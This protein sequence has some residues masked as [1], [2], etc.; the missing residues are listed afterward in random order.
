VDTVARIAKELQVLR[1]V[2]RIFITQSRDH[3]AGAQNQLAFQGRAHEP[4]NKK[5]FGIDGIPSD[6]SIREI[7]D[8]IDIEHLNEA[9]ANTFHELQSG[10][11]LRQFVFR[12]DHY[13]LAID[14][15]GYCCLTSIAQSPWS[16]KL[17]RAI[18]SL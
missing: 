1:F 2:S 8:G 5:P 15:A 17:A 6:T 9:F 4:A 18:L 10:S 3:D 12:N 13:Q 16:I 14:G 11:V 7:L